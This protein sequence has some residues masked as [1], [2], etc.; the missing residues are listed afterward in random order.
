[1][2]DEASLDGMGG[3]RD[4]W[5]RDVTPAHTWKPQPPVTAYFSRL[6]PSPLPLSCCLRRKNHLS[7]RIR[8]RHLRKRFRQDMEAAALF[9]RRQPLRIDI[10]DV[11]AA[12]LIKNRAV[13]RHDHRIHHE[14]IP[15]SSWK[16]NIIACCLRRT[17]SQQYQS[18]SKTRIR[19][20]LRCIGVP[21]E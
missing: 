9:Q 11:H 15:L 19:A 13:L 3:V 8:E 1:V 18:S 21:P 12:D 4:E 16:W 2:A 6:S 10:N 17:R 14:P 7:P 5:F 20:S